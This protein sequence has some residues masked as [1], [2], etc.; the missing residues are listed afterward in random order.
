[1]PEDGDVPRETMCHISPNTSN[2][3]G[4]RLTVT[5]VYVDLP[6]TS[7]CGQQL[8]AENQDNVRLFSVCSP[9]WFR[10]HIVYEGDANWVTLHFRSQTQSV[11]I[12]RAWKD[13][14]QSPPSLFAW[15]YI[16]GNKMHMGGGLEPDRLE[17]KL[18]VVNYHKRSNLFQFNN[19]NARGGLDSQNRWRG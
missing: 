17:R 2:R 13:N 4:M 5:L 18:C 14:T 8:W 12:K 11:R 9:Q 7:S 10:Q 1:M 16:Q 6:R 19:I 3:S 15:M